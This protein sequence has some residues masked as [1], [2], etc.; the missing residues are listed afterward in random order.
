MSNRLYSILSGLAILVVW[1]LAAQIFANRLLPGPLQVLQFMSEEI[2]S[3]DLIWH[4]VITLCRVAAVY[5]VA[6][7]I[8][9][10]VGLA[11]GRSRKVDRI[12]DPWL[13]V[14]LN[15]PA[16]VVIILAFVWVGLTEVAAIS[17]VAINKIPNVVVTL[18]EGARALDP[19]LDEMAKTFRMSRSDVLRHVTLPQL[20]PYFAAASRSGLALIWKIVLVVELLGRSNGVGFQIHLYF[21]LFDVTG[22]LAYTIAFVFVMLFVEILLVQPLE[23]RASRWRIKPA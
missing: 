16:L 19:G 10:V 5:F 9:S 21:Q 1:A 8:G 3:G 11:M 22:I 4:L 17:A 18:R 7:T 6:M 13:I 12:L 23:Q 15:I 20:Q 2:R 14:L